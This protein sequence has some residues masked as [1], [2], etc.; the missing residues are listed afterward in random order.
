MRASQSWNLILHRAFSLLRHV[1]WRHRYIVASSDHFERAIKRGNG[2][3]FA[4]KAL[5]LNEGRMGAGRL[6]QFG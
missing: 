1:C 6:S 4:I 5:N 2:F 3:D